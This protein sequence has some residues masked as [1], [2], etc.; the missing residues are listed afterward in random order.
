M[1]SGL[2][3]YAPTGRTARLFRI[4]KFSGLVQWFFSRNRCGS[5]AHTFRRF[6]GSYEK[7]PDSKSGDR[8]VHYFLRRKM[9]G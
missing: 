1:A 3:T 7:A 6:E 8:F 9:G 2:V 5:V 4:T